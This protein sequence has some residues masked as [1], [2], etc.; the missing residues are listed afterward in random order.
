ITPTDPEA[1]EDESSEQNAPSRSKYYQLTHDYLV[2]SLRDWLTRKQ[3]ETRRGR[4]E[5]RLAERAALWNAKPEQRQLPSPLEWLSIRLYTAPRQWTGAQRRM[6][7]AAGRK[8]LTAAA[9]LSATFLC[10]AGALFFLRS[11]LGK[12][13]ASTRADGM[14]RRLLDAHLS[15]TPEI[16]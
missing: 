6:M 1:G 8:H 2:H 15:N 13:R 12:E 9:A 5:L 4:A 14:V 3:Q 16:I 10:L 7:S 11:Q